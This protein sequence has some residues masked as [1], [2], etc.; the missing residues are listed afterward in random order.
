MSPIKADLNNPCSAR[1][2]TSKYNKRS[3]TV[4]FYNATRQQQ[5]SQ[6]NQQQTQFRDN[7][8]KPT[9]D[10]NAI[11]ATTTRTLNSNTPQ[12]VNGGRVF[13]TDLLSTEKNFPIYD[14]VIFNSQSSNPSGIEPYSKEEQQHGEEIFLYMQSN[15]MYILT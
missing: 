1:T 11:S 2:T 14:T 3:G 9:T 8:T 12:L 4:R 13:G 6:A 5:Q 7:A 15:G 10:G